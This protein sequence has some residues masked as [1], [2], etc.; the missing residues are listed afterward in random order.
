MANSVQIR[1]A[2]NTLITVATI[3]ST[4]ANTAA[5][6]ASRTLLSDPITGSGATVTA[7]HNSDNQ[8]FSG[9]ISGVMT[10]GV[11]QLLNGAGNLDRKRGVSGDA[12]PVTG[13]AAEV[14]LLWNGATYDRQRGNIDTTVFTLTGQAT[15]VLSSAD[16]INYNGRGIQVFLNI[17]AATAANIALT[18]QGK[19]VASGTYYPLLVTANVAT[20][21][22]LYTVYPGVTVAANVAVSQ[23][24]PRTWRIVANVTATSVTAT[25]GAS[26]LIA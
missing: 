20:G 22:V 14:L 7:F 2:S 11:D 5:G 1:D 10:G 18:I 15:A 16:Q 6:Q 17:T 13:L 12:M 26:V 25:I 3:D 9:S 21:G 23:C 4:L 8:S 19:D 24:L